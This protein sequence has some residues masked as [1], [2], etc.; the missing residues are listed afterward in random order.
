MNPNPVDPTLRCANRQ[1][2][3]LNYTQMI[4][5]KNICTVSPKRNIKLKR[6]PHQLRSPPSILKNPSVPLSPHNPQQ[7]ETRYPPESPASIRIPKT[8]K[9]NH[10]YI[11]N[12]VWLNPLHPHLRKDPMPQTQSDRTVQKEMINHL[13]TL[14]AEDALIRAKG[15]EMPPQ[16]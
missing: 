8:L 13:T 9:G 16:L 6:I 4:G 3:K 7:R 15:F 1:P 2:V 12:T 5:F 14:L 10:H 11:A